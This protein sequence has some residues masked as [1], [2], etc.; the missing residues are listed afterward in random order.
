LL[1]AESV[2]TWLRDCYAIEFIARRKGYRST[3]L[4]PST[5]YLVNIQLL[6]LGRSEGLGGLGMNRDSR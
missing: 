3:N 6:T 1:E 2:L 5:D 4:T